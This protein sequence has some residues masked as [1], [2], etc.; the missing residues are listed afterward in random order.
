LGTRRTPSYELHD[1]LRNKKNDRR[2]IKDGDRPLNR[3]Q[4]K[5]F[6][7]P[8]TGKEQPL[9]A[10]PSQ[11]AANPDLLSLSLIL[12]INNQEHEGQGWYTQTASEIEILLHTPA[13]G[14]HSRY[15]YY[16]VLLLATGRGAEASTAP[17]LKTET[18]SV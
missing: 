18:S 7:K 10:L 5:I 2:T 12:S 13:A 16:V 17:T 6:T 1:R 15:W 14:S 8:H 4:S 3:N 9:P 11:W